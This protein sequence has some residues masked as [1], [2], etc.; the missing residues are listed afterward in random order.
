[1][2]QF[3]DDQAAWWLQ[4]TLYS[5]GGRVLMFSASCTH[6]LFHSILPISTDC[7]LPQLA[8]LIWSVCWPGRQARAGASSSDDEELAAK[9]NKLRNRR[10]N[11][12]RDS[13]DL[14]D[15][16]SLDLYRE[17]DLL[18]SLA[19]AADQGITWQ[20]LESGEAVQL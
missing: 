19:G 11:N 7:S 16:N 4:L 1:M 20:H 12:N 18:D 3:S 2:R 5:S 13:P 14:E 6:P 9:P 17:E 15:L 8:P 10:N